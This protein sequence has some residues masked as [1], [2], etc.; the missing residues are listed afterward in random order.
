MTAGADPT[1]ASIASPITQLGNDMPACSLRALESVVGIDHGIEVRIRE[2]AR[3]RLSCG[4]GETNPACLTMAFHD[5]LAL[6]ASRGSDP[7]FDLSL[8]LACWP[9]AL[10]ENPFFQAKPTPHPGRFMPSIP[11]AATAPSTL[12][13]FRRSTRGLARRRHESKRLSLWTNVMRFQLRE[14]RTAL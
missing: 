12:S 2:S 8:K 1:A 7:T 14:T 13:T 5:P 3:C 11:S 6:L 4:K 10:H 9:S